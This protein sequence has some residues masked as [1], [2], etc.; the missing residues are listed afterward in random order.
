M[1]R[2]CVVQ[3]CTHARWGKEVSKF[4]DALYRVVVTKQSYD[5]EGPSL[6]FGIMSRLSG[7]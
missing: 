6:G 4:S 1:T 7:K 2:S 3:S 5:R